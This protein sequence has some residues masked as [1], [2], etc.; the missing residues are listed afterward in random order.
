MEAV[1]ETKQVVKP[2]KPVTNPKQETGQ[3]KGGKKNNG[4]SNNRK[5]G[6]SVD[7]AIK[8]AL[9]DLGCEIEDVIIEIIEEPTKGL[10]GIV[11]KKP[12]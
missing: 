6:K 3:G 1:T 10:L 5:R 11:G 12:R 7:E 4:G 8:S 2:T 9:E